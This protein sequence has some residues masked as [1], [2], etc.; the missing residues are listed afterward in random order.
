MTPCPCGRSGYVARLEAH[1]AGGTARRQTRMMACHVCRVQAHRSFGFS[2]RPPDGRPFRRRTDREEE[3]GTGQSEAAGCERRSAR[4]DRIATSTPHVG[5]ELRRRALWQTQTELRG[6]GPRE[7]H[8]Q[9]G[10]R[11][12][13]SQGDQIKTT[14]SGRRARARARR[15]I[16]VDT[17]W[18]TLV[19]P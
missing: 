15:G 6:I 4:I 7:R 5:A 12:I 3:K 13:G 10:S 9:A 16:A 19:T 14:L 1:S 18:C 8:R 17:A 11:V 2:E